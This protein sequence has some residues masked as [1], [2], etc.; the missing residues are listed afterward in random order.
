MTLFPKCGLVR[1]VLLTVSLAIVTPVG[2]AADSE[3]MGL[4]LGTYTRGKSQ[5]IYQARLDT[6]TGKLHALDLAAELE[7]PSFLARHPTRPVVYAVGEVNNFGGE[8]SAGAVS[9]LKRDPASGRLELLNQQTTGGA[10]PCHVSVT[11]C[12]KFVMVANYSGG[13][14]A[15]YPVQEDGSLGA[16]SGFVQHEGSSVSPRQKGPHAHSINPD[17]AGRFFYAADLGIDKI[18]IYRLDG[19][20]LV[21]SQPAFAALA[22]GSGP[23]H[24]TF[25]PNG[26]YA[27]G[28][29]ELLSTITAFEYNAETGALAEMQT[30]GTLPEGFEGQNT[31]ADVHVHPSG[32]FLYGS[33]RGHDSIAAYRIDP[34]SGKLALLGHASSGGKSPRNFGID[35]SGRYLLAAHQESDNVVAFRIDGETGLLEPTGSELEPGSPVCVVFLPK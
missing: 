3:G 23:R 16:M 15:C 28:I 17:P 7:N 27:Y 24:F 29:N 20:K 9:A 35:P 32:K 5:G 31:T 4:Y 6:E 26:R 10:H 34:A 22:P 1:F 30:I 25:H 19:G 12:G 21:P 18:F 33:N 2:F 14:V 11:P 8:K 13:S